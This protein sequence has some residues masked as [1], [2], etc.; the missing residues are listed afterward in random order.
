MFLGGV[1]SGGDIQYVKRPV[2]ILINSIGAFLLVKAYLRYYRCAAL[3]VFIKHM[4]FVVLFHAL[5]MIMQYMLPWF[6]DAVYLLTSPF[7]IV[8]VDNSIQTGKR[9]LGLTYGLSSTSLIQMTGLF[10]Y[11]Y[12]YKTRQVSSNY[13]SIG[14]V[15]IVGSMF[16]SGRS[17]IF[18]ALIL[19]PI[20]ILWNRN[21]KIRLFL[22]SVLSLF[23]LYWA[24]AYLFPL[25]CDHAL[26]ND[27]VRYTL[28]HMEELIGFFSGSSSKTVTHIIAELHFPSELSILLFGGVNTGIDSGYFKDIY[29]AGIGFML[30]SIVVY[31]LPLMLALLSQRRDELLTMTVFVFLAAIIYH[32]KE[33]GFF[34]R[35]LWSIHVLLLLFVILMPKDHLK[36]SRI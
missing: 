4:Y 13:Y 12:L 29:T 26:C 25:Y 2:R 36:N 33:V 19:L 6:R 34:V 20:Y 5:I 16:I 18:L 28:W 9:I 17:G 23:C 7:G 10:L 32:G 24:F 31:S 11:V 15:V 22:Y 30:L 21:N 14:L 27:S 8:N 35:G 1:F 3:S